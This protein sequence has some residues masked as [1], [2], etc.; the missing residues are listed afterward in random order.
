MFRCINLKSFINNISLGSPANKSWIVENRCQPSPIWLS[1][2]SLK[3]DFAGTTKEYCDR[4]I[5]CREKANVNN[6]GCAFSL[7]FHLAIPDDSTISSDSLILIHS[8][9]SPLKSERPQLFDLLVPE[10][11][12][13]LILSLSLSLSHTH[14]HTHTLEYILTLITFY[15]IFP[16]T[17]FYFP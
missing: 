17:S 12:L 9:N 14:T 7:E 16:I 8:F 5:P 4:Q 1:S 11:L 15:S 6:H 2:F 3:D 13:V 10:P